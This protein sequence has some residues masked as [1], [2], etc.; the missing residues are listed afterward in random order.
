MPACGKASAAA[1][2]PI[3]LRWAESPVGCSNPQQTVMFDYRSPQPRASR[4]LAILTRNSI[5]TTLG[6]ASIDRKGPAFSPGHR[7]ENA[8]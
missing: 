6:L 3:G 2:F 4:Q 1:L 8:T 5:A 7:W